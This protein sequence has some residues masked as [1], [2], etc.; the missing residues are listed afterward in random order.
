M[1]KFNKVANPGHPNEQGNME[2]TGTCHLGETHTPDVGES[3]IME[4]SSTQARNIDLKNMNIDQVVVKL[5]PA[6]DTFTA[7][8]FSQRNSS[9]DLLVSFDLKTFELRDFPYL[10]SQSITK[11]LSCYFSPP[12]ENRLM[13]DLVLH[14]IRPTCSVTPPTKKSVSWSKQLMYKISLQFWK[15]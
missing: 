15:S 8:T 5:S 13:A 7:R 9:L 2:Q 3:Q 10:K 11:L 12:K 6:Q 1:M 14:M 4:P